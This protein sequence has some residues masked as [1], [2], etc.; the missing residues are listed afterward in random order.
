MLAATIL[1]T[2]LQILTFAQD[3][4]FTV[5][6]GS[7]AVQPATVRRVTRLVEAGLAR[8]GPSFPGTQVSSLV[9]HLHADLDSVPIDIRR[10]LH[11]GTAGL[12]LLQA[13]QIHLILTEARLRPP[14]DLRSVVD[15][16]LVHILLHQHSG[17]GADHVPRWFHEGL[18][19]ELSG[20]TYLGMKETDIAIPARVQRLLR[21]RDLRTGFPD[22]DYPLRLAYGQ[23]F[24]YVAFLNRKFG[25]KT[26]LRAAALADADQWFRGGFLT[27]T[28][29]ALIHQ[30]ELWLDY[31]ENDSGALWRRM[32]TDCFSYLMIPGTVLLIWATRRALLR[33]RRS[34]R[35]LEQD[36]IDESEEL[37][38]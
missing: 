28:G 25:L 16:E 6:P 14:G 36:E 18:A 38:A 19:Q 12:A 9:I 31:L 22:G 21:F 35:R 3:P 8:L 15:H 17:D 10:Y 1:P 4:G 37:G 2:I 34:K 32:R 33:D 27:T 24:S 11:P 5:I 30:E 13:N 7:A 23:S 26:L 20:A 29:G